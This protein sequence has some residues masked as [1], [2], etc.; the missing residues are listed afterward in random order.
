MSGT[1]ISLQGDARVMGVLRELV[2]RASDLTPAMRNIGEG[3][4]TSTQVRFETETDPE[5]RPW[6]PLAVETLLRRAAHS[7]KRKN[8]KGESYTVRSAYNAKGDMTAAAQKRLKSLKILQHLGHLKG[9]IHQAAGRDQVEVGSNLAY[10][11]IH[12]YGGQAGRGH[13][14]TIPARPFL[15]ISEGDA[16]MIVEILGTYLGGLV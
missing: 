11:R 15:G 13:K 6:K 1:A 3:L 14:V 2:S 8:A 16:D 5:G 9:S 4:V 10:A 12:Q 7:Q